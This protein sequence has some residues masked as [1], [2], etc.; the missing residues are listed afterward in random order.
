ME[1]FSQK[2]H[3]GATASRPADGGTEPHRPT[4]GGVRLPWRTF[5]ERWVAPTFVLV[6]LGYFSLQ[7]L[8]RV[9]SSGNLGL[10]EAEQMVMAQSL[11]AG[12][13]PQ[14]P[15]YTWLV[16]ALRPLT[17][18]GVLTLATVKFGLLALT[19]LATF[20]LCRQL[21]GE[22]LPAA[23]A[24]LSILYL[25]QVAWESQRAL[26]HSVIALAAVALACTLFVDLV[27][28]RRTR[29]YGLF[30]VAL[31]ACALSKHNAVFLPL[32]LLA[33]G[34]LLPG[35][36]PALLD[37][38]LLL[39]LGLALLLMLPNLIWMAVNSEAVLARSGKFD[40]EQTTGPLESLRAFG[41]ALLNFALLPAILLPLLALLPSKEVAPARKIDAKV[42]Q[43]LTLGLGLAALLVLS[44]VVA[45][46]ADTM[47]DRWLTPVLFP[48]VPVA[49]AWIA[50]RLDRN[51]LRLA[52]TAAVVIALGSMAVLWLRQFAPADWARPPNM[53][54]PFDSLAP[55]LPEAGLLLSSSNWVAGNLVLHRPGL[56]AVT[57]EYRAALDEPLVGPILLVWQAHEGERVPASLAA[58]ASARRGNALPGSLQ[59]EVLEALFPGAA[60]LSLRIVRLEAAA[61]MPKSLPSPYEL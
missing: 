48:A 14:P 4:T 27:T 15:L 23:V 57:P 59:V 44:L 34:L 26:T 17:G 3:T 46:S 13:G 53:E 20:R 32:G 31:A 54:A 29:D 5:D 51:R 36:R 37:R 11:E 22:P 61:D 30:A 45:A 40:L 7:V 2:R 49:L 8:F 6:V 16:L 43:L 35:T 1:P 50:T 38:R 56:A 55:S 42:R 47:K 21:F 60:P 39:A 9:L 28:K 25:P 24:A 33:A 12:Y 41:R 10:D 18:D 52:A 58:L 19:L